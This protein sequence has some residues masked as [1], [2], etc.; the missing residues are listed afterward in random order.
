MKDTAM[1]DVCDFDPHTY[2]C[3]SVSGHHSNDPAP[4]PPDPSDDCVVS[5]EKIY[6]GMNTDFL[7]N[8]LLTKF[9][10]NVSS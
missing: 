3:G 10:N 6:T 2:T 4:T 5:E 1:C 9:N 8:H 7:G